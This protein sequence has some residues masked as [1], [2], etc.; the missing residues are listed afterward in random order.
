[1]TTPKWIPPW[2]KDTVAPVLAIM[3][4]AGG[5][6]T[7]WWHPELKTEIVALMTMVLMYY[8]GSSRGSDNKTEIMASTAKLL[9][10][11]EATE[12]K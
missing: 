12:K 2:L 4:L 8:F 11:G 9:A 1:M 10:E 6:A 5:F 3:T 7:L